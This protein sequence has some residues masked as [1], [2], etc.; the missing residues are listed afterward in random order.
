[1]KNIIVLFFLITASI[2]SQ[3]WN[4]EVATNLPYTNAPYSKMDMFANKDGIHMVVRYD[5]NPD[6]YFK[7]LLSGYKLNK[8]NWLAGTE[9]L[10]V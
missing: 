8:F 6:S 10:K 5:G 9:L 4:N 1:M 3:S 7:S 2:L